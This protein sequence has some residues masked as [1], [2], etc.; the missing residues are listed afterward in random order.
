VLSDEHEAEI[1][2]RVKGTID[3]AL[4]FAINAPDPAP[5]AAVTDLYA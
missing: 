4:D 5:E 2:A 1:D 3:D